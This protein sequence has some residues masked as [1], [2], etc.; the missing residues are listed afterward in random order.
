MKFRHCPFWHTAFQVLLLCTFRFKSKCF[1]LVYVVD[2]PLYGSQCSWLLVMH[3]CVIPT[4][5]SGWTLQLGYN[6]QT[7]LWKV[8]DLYSSPLSC[9]FFLSV[10]QSLYL[11]LYLSFFCLYGCM[12]V[13]IYVCKI[14]F[15]FLNPHWWCP[16]SLE[17]G[18]HHYQG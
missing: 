7:D 18:W 14:S 17:G 10:S 15:P 4:P 9:S 13:C 16:A 3:P 8:C 11:C 6:I 1:I 12:H 5:P 2:W